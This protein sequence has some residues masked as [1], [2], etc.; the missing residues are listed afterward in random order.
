[1]VALGILWAFIKLAT[2]FSEKKK[3]T[4]IRLL[5]PISSNNP[6][7]PPT[8]FVLARYQALAVNDVTPVESCFPRDFQLVHEME[9]PTFEEFKD[10]AITLAGLV[11]LQL[12]CLVSRVSPKSPLAQLQYLGFPFNMSAVTLNRHFSFSPENLNQGRYHTVVTNLFHHAGKA[13]CH[14]ATDSSRP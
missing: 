9:G 12:P 4:K 11:G 1:M 7:S 10:C 3:K 5:P 14:L 8:G 13:E 6:P 2:S